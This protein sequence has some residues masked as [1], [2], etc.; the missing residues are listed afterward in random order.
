MTAPLPTILFAAFS[1]L[2]IAAVLAR[3]E[4]EQKR[5]DI[6]NQEQIAWKR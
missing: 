6:I 4:A 5:A 1:A 3:A 2:L